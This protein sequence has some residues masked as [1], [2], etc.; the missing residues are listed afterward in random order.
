[1]RNLV[2]ICVLILIAAACSESKDQYTLKGKVDGTTPGWIKLSKVADNA[3]VAVDSVKSNDGAF[4]FTGKIEMPEVY[5]LEFVNDE[6]SVRIFVED[7][8]IDITGR[9]DSLVVRGS[10]S[11]DIFQKYQN[12]IDTLDMSREALY[13]DFKVAM[14]TG[15]TAAIAAI[16]ARAQQIDDEQDAFHKDFVMAQSDNVVG[17]YIVVNNIYT[18]DLDE[19]KSARAQFGNEVLESKY[20]D[21]LDRQI[22]KL[23]KVAIGEVAPAFTQNDTA[24]RAVSLSD[25]QGKYLLIDFWASWCSPCRQEN[26]NVVLAWQRFHDQGFDV[27]GVSL[28][29]NR[30]AWLKAIAD[31]H[32]TW[33]QV[34]DLKYWNNEASNLYAV[35]SIPANFLLDPEG[36]IIAKDLRGE[37]LQNTLADVF[38][39]K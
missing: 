31:D 35:S 23:Q 37:D 9:P 7:K 17:P 2:W 36:I 25:F 6:K 32:L 5:Y 33:T 34:S 28:D 19:M 14:Q 20:V 13:A 8:K 39:N 15:D 10:P 1:M 16:Q 30:S 4:S 18:Y 21:I 27:L 3:L 24:N 22:A 26:P 12:E 38:N 11:H 29:K